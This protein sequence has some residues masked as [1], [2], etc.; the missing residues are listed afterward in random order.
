MAKVGSG[1]ANR[2]SRRSIEV[3]QTI[4]ILP[5]AFVAE[6][7]K[8]R[9]VGALAELS[10]EYGIN[11]I[12]VSMVCGAGRMARGTFYGHFSDIKACRAYALAEAFDRTFGI[13]KDPRLQEAGLEASL[14]ALFASIASEPI[15]AELCL[16]HSF[17]ALEEAGEHGHDAAVDVVRHLLRQHLTLEGTVVEEGLARSIVFETALRLRQRQASDLLGKEQDWVIMLKAYSSR[18]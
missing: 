7:Q 6:H 5:R 10:S 17:G 18:G 12:T 14:A 9:V 11:A 3:R 1:R 2:R 13:A 16:V 8:R 15:L 4:P